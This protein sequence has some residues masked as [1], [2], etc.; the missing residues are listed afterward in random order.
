MPLKKIELFNN[1]IEYI[2]IDKSIEEQKKEFGQYQINTFLGHTLIISNIKYISPE[3]MDFFINEKNI[4][5][6]FQDK[7]GHTFL[8]TSLAN[9]NYKL[10]N[11]LLENGANPN[12]CNEFQVYPIH[13]SVTQDLK[14]TKKLLAAK[15]FDINIQDDEGSTILMKACSY[16]PSVLQEQKSSIQKQIEIIKLLIE[17]GAD[18]DIKNQEGLTSLDIASNTK[19]EYKSFIEHYKITRTPKKQTNKAKKIL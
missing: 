19:K 18:P 1:Q 9:N 5:I 2:L 14:I 6:N 11:Y 13:L 12:Q 16:F 7:N 4:D 8:I 17:H 15:D 10:T 3:L